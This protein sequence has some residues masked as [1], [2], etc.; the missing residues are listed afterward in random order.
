[1][2][3][4]APYILSGGQVEPYCSLTEVK[5]SPTASSIDFTNLVENGAQSAQDRALYELIVRASSKIDA[6]CLGP[7]GTL[8]ATS[9]TENGRYRLD[10]LGRFRISPAMK[11]VIEV[12]NFVWGTN[13][14][15]TYTVPVST[16]NTWIERDSI[17]FQAQG[18]AGVNAVAGMQALSWII[19]Q[20]YYGEYYC[21]WTYVN[22]WANSFTTATSNIGDTSITVQN[23]TGFVPNQNFTLWDG[24]ND[25]YCQIASSYNGT[26]TTIPLVS[27]LQYKHGSGVN[28]STLP[29]V[30]KQACIHF[31]VGMVKQRGQGGIVLN[32]MGAETMVAGKSEMSAEDEMRGYDL[33]DEFKS[34]W[35]RL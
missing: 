9:N 4:I 24:V 33:L 25:E 34:V 28:V 21:E 23:A 31:V 7:Y 13:M 5:F 15:Q 12:T 2:S 11:P 10:R 27:G 26:S 17:I 14:G 6:Y 29:A 20:P 32:E 1:M 22:G 35:G 8:N 16:Q 18:A 30:I 19:G 3:V